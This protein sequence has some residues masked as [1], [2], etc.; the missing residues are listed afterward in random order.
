M[1]PLGALRFRSSS[2][3]VFRNCLIIF[4]SD[5]RDTIA[6]IAD[7]L[8]CG[9]DTVV[10]VRGLYRNGGI[11][12]LHPIKPPGRRGRA[13]PAFIKA[14]KKG[15]WQQSDEARLRLLRLVGGTTGRT[16]GEGDRHSFRCR[17]L[18]QEGFSIQLLGVVLPP[19]SPRY[20]NRVNCFFTA[21]NLTTQCEDTELNRKLH[22]SAISAANAYVVAQS[23][24][25][26]PPYAIAKLYFKHPPSDALDL[27]LTHDVIL[28]ASTI[29]NAH[30]I[31]AVQS[32]EGLRLETE[33]RVESNS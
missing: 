1:E 6:T 15:G 19:T 17:S 22:R 24:H 28:R 30:G 9:T 29:A 32:V 10:R 2:A 27:S 25:W 16:S 4:M 14:I 11:D 5:S 8:G 31:S 21:I 23:E 18:R 33:Q 20:F 12:V 26:R 3:D 13:T 7:R